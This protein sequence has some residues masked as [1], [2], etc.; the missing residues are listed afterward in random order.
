[1]GAEATAPRA[2]SMKSTWRDKPWNELNRHQKQMNRLALNPTGK[3]EDVPVFQKTDPVQYLPHWQG[4]AWILYHAA[5]PMIVHQGLYWYLGK[6]IHPIAAFFLYTAAFNVNAVHELWALRDLGMRYGFLDGDKHERDQVP[7]GSATKVMRAL[8]S[9]STLRPMLAVFLSYSSKQLPTDVFSW[10]TPLEIGLYGIVLDF[11]FYWYHRLMHEQDSLWKFHRTH[12]LTK[13]PTPLLT[14]YAD[15]VQET[16]DIAVIPLLTWVTLRVM[17]F[18]MGFYETWLCHQYVVFTELFGHSGIRLWVTPPTTATW[19]LKYFNAELTTEDHDLHHRKGYRQSH[20][21][22]KQTFLWDRIF[23]TGIDR[24]ET[25]D[26]NVQW[27][28]P[29]YMKLGC[30]LF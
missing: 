23:G 6:N 12:H 26:G 16:F 27:D 11:W 25:Y 24:I 15:Y 20:N 22:G 17:G 7:D 4:H 8:L 29:A 14:I 9:T 18:P 2:E 28:N 3:Q 13:H 10:W 21:Y 30:P 5:W 1:M 19:F